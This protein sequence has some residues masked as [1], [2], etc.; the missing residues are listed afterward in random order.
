LLPRFLPPRRERAGAEL[1]R[2]IDGLLPLVLDLL[3]LVMGGV[4]SARF[5][6]FELGIGSHGSWTNIR[7]NTAGDT[8]SS[9]NC[10]DQHF[11][12]LGVLKQVQQ[13]EG[14]CNAQ[15]PSLCA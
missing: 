6:F 11:D 10:V 8:A 9:L 4:L 7:S 15:E 2:R 1:L 13:L 5:F 3:L 12:A 14:P